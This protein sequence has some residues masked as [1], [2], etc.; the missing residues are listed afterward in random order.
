MEPQGHI[1]PAESQTGYS[2]QAGYSQ[3]GYSQGGY[4]HGGYNNQGGYI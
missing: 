3:G 4:S 1:G 2:S